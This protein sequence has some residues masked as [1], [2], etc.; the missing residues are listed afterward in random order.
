[1][2]PPSTIYPV[3]AGQWGCLSSAYPGWKGGGGFTQLK[4]EILTFAAFFCVH[5]CTS[6]L[7]SFNN[8]YLLFLQ[9]YF[10][11]SALNFRFPQQVWFTQ[12]PV[13]SLSLALS[14]SE[15]WQKRKEK[16]G[17]SELSWAK[18]LLSQRQGDW[19][20]D[21]PPFALN[22]KRVAESSLVDCEPHQI[23]SCVI[24]APS[25]RLWLACSRLG[26]F[27]WLFTGKIKILSLLKLIFARWKVHLN[28]SFESPNC[29]LAT[30]ED[31]EAWECLAPRLCRVHCAPEHVAPVVAL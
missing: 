15:G 14:L 23:P 10:F 20:G 12:R 24:L 16:K 6:F 11:E 9:N 7:S 29:W 13:A 28:V 2:Q 3:T 25:H 18:G 8:F 31:S 19:A 1:M 30:L 17:G 21:L 5:L 27:L 26:K 22:I 4:A